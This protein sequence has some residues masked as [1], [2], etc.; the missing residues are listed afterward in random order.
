M[1]IHGVIAAM[2]RLLLLLLWAPTLAGAFSVSLSRHVPLKFEGS[3]LGVAAEIDLYEHHE[4]ADVSLKGF[5]VGGSV[6]GRAE[7][8]TDGWA[9]KI[10]DNL[11]AALSRRRVRIESVGMFRNEAKLWV[12]LVLPLIGRRVMWLER[13]E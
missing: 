9:V 6:S 2:H 10:D 4:C 3:M 5:P 8:E 11:K 12:M 1:A 13:V 7:F